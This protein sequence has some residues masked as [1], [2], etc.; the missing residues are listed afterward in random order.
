[1][2]INTAAEA[3]DR[4]LQTY[5]G[6]GGRAPTEVRAHPSGDDMTHI[7][8]WVNL[9]ADAENDDLEAWCEEAKGALEKAL[10][11]DLAGWTVEMRADAM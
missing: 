7:K 5:K 4:F 6:K 2:D 11:K 3:V 10:G 1:M 8:V 9:G